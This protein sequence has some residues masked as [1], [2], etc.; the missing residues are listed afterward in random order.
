VE[1]WKSQ[2]DGDPQDKCVDCSE[3]QAVGDP[4]DAASRLT[5]VTSVYLLALN[6]DR[7]SLCSPGCPKTHSENQAD[8]KLTEICLPL[9]GLKVCATTA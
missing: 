4:L 1:M 8:L 6:K 7:V 2:T 9:L 5:T 3:S